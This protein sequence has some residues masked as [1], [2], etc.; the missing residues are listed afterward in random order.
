MDIHRYYA[1]LAQARQRLWTVLSDLPDEV[2]A[3]RLVEGT[4]SS[5]KELVFHVTNCEDGWLHLDVLRDEMV[6]RRSPRFAPLAEGHARTA[7]WSTLHAYQRQVESVTLEYL[8]EVGPDETSRV[9]TPY[10]DPDW[11]MQVGDVLWH[12]MTHEVRHTAQLALALRAAGVQPPG[13]DFIG[14]VA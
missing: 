14:Y 2:G 1:Y 5:P 8:A 12:V 9:M 4:A 13:L 10:D 11:S 3:T 6:V 7:P